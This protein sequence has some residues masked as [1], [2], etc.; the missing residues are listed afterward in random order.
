[1]AALNQQ[2]SVAIAVAGLTGATTFAHD[3]LDGR[4][5]SDVCLALRRVARKSCAYGI[6]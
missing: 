4:A 2:S 3:G 1:M 6:T 5:F